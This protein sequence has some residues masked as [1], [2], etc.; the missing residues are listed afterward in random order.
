[1]AKKK[2][3]KKGKRKAFKKKEKRTL[4][5]GIAHIQATFNNTHITISDVEGNV[6]AW[7]SCWWA[8]DSRAR[9]RELLSRRSRRRAKSAQAVRAMGCKSARSA[10]QG[11][12]LGSRIGDSRATG[13]GHRRQIHPGR[14][15]DSAQR[16]P[17][18]EAT[19]SLS[20]NVIKGTGR[21]VSGMLSEC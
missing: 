11:S 19:E 8:R 14:D 21:R 16:L 4:L 6:V 7:A 18:S 10:S 13:R 2:D 15:T 9:A 12:G 20:D 1:M 17:A 3:D 5:S